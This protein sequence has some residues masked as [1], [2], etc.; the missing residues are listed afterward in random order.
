MNINPLIESALSEIG[1]PVDTIE[2]D[3]TEDVYIVYYT[4][5]ENDELYADD[6]PIVEG[7]YGTVTIFSK[8]DFKT[9][10]ND[11]K[12]KLRQAGFTILPGGPEGFEDG[13]GYYTWPIEI[14]IEEGLED[15]E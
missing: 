9:L 2:H 10:A 11:V 4:Y 6:A 5:S 14:Y 1:C 15:E 13:T 3:G 7:T 8:G 12:S